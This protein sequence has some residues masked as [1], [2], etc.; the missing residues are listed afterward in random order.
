M[1]K[2]VLAS[3]YSGNIYEIAKQLEEIERLNFGPQG[4]RAPTIIEEIEAIGSMGVFLFDD[5]RVVGY[6]AMTPARVIYTTYSHYFNR[7]HDNVAYLTN[8][9]L[10]PEYQHKGYFWQ[11]LDVLMLE[12]KKAKFVWLDLDAIADNGF[13]DKFVPKLGR[14]VVF[15]KPPVNT[16]WGRQRY[17][18][19][20]L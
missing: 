13:A 3:E 1:I 14:R 11:M 6:I 2:I 17:I 4:F 5:E 15:A 7:D 19:I 10:H 18:R 16:E 20:E 8:A 9:S 12:L